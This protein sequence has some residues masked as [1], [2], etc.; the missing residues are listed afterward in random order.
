MPCQ[1]CHVHN[2]SLA[3]ILC[4]PFDHVE[5]RKFAGLPGW[6]T[7]WDALGLEDTTYTRKTLAPLHFRECANI[8]MYPILLEKKGKI[9]EYPSGGVLS[10]VC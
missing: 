1:V 10:G 7:L 2:Y 8:H 9:S 6:L 5:C 3:Y 4:L